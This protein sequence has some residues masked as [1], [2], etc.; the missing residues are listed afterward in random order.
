MDMKINGD[1]VKRERQQRAWSQEHLAGATGVSLRTIQRIET[2]G[3]ASYDSLNALAAVFSLSVAE[4]RLPEAAP[5][6]AH[7][8]PKPASEKWWTGPRFL[9]LAGAQVIAMVI[10]PPS[11][12]MSMTTG[13]MLWVGFE[14]LMLAWRRQRR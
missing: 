7:E 1:R 8:I 9:A 2:T 13:V 6:P 12:W 4:L 10:A 3:T 5:P 11:V 14:L